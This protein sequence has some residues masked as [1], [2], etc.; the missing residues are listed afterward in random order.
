[1]SEPR[2][3]APVPTLVEVS[4][5]SAAAVAAVLAR[6]HAEQSRLTAAEGALVALPRH[7]GDDA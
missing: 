4:T 6:L 2:A 5:L 1:M 7:P 3:L